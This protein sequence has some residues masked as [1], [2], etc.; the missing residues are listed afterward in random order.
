MGKQI[1]V[2]VRDDETNRQI[3][4]LR[5]EKPDEIKSESA[6]EERRA[7]AIFLES[8]AKEIHKL[9]SR[10][11]EDFIEMPKDSGIELRFPV[12]LNDRPFEII[13]KEFIVE[14]K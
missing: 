3:V 14:I 4:A 12:S 8:L 11:F 2:I 6:L 5:Y 13:K 9:L 1:E 7:T 10:K